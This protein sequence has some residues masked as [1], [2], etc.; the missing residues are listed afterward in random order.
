[1]PQPARL[2]TEPCHLRRSA[3][4]ATERDDRTAP[5]GSAGPLPR[6][7]AGRDVDAVEEAD[8]RD[9][10]DERS[11]LGLVVVPGDLGSGLIGDRVRPIAETRHA[12]GQRQR[13]PFRVSVVRRIPPAG[14]RE[15]ALLR[16]AGSPGAL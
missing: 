16:F 11:Q 9:V 8:H 4:I 15:E 3:I 10:D 5:S 12:F 2:P 1:M 6:D 14:Q 13:G 7:L